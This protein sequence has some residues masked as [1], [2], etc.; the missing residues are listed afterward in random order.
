M[1]LFKLDTIV[2]SAATF[3]TNADAQSILFDAHSTLIEHTFFFSV[4]KYSFFFF[5]RDTKTTFSTFCTFNATVKNA[6]KMFVKRTGPILHQLLTVT[7]R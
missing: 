2:N 1:M 6:E 7:L 4:A 3:E 5:N